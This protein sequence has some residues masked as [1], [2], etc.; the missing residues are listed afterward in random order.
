MLAVGEGIPANLVHVRVWLNLALL[1][2]NKDVQ[3]TIDMIGARMTK[4]QV[5]EARNPLMQ[6]LRAPQ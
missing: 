4:E 3:P 1:H 5:D 2:G 6:K